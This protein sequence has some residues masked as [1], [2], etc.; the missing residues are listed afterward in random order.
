MK[1][2][3]ELWFGFILMALIIAG[4]HDR[5]LDQAT[6]LHTALLRADADVT[7]ISLVADHGLIDAD[8]EMAARWMAGEVLQPS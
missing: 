6:E 2:R 7:M 1:I 3:K 5:F 8:I 4:T